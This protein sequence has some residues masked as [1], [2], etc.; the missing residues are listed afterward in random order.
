[1]A[2]D[3]EAV[4]TAEALAATET[5]PVEEEKPTEGEPETAEK[6]E[7][8][9][10]EPEVAPEKPD[11]K[12]FQAMRHRIQELEKEAATK[13]AEVGPL[14]PRIETPTPQGPEVVNQNQ[15]FNQETGEFDAVGYQ[16]A[17]RA[18]AMKAANEI[19]E[20]RIEEERQTQEAYVS[21]PALNPSVKEFDQDLYDAT[22]AILLQ[23]MVKGQ[24]V[25]VKQAAEK[26]LGLSK[27]ALK[28]AADT[29]AK[30]ELENIAAKEAAALEATASS[31]R[32][33]EDLSDVE[34][35]SDITRQGGPEG[36]AAITERLK[37]A[38]H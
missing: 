3:K 19:T 23:S 25:T 29:G 18:D 14:V 27:K 38:G 15:F 2:E 8:T 35:L 30:Q 33:T 13:S 16:N 6:P 20:L 26:A 17:V 12:A 10:E 9:P 5:P 1:M 32:A 21:Y 36:Q 28:E 31:G 24:K 11:A 34:R 37:R 7:E 4:K 22:S